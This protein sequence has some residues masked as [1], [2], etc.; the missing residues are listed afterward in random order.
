MGSIT[1]DCVNSALESRS[2]FALGASAFPSVSSS[3]RD[4][5]TLS[6]TPVKPPA[7]SYTPDHAHAPNDLLAPTGPVQ[8]SD[9][10]ELPPPPPT[11]APSQ[12]DNDGNYVEDVSVS[13][14]NPPNMETDTENEDEKLIK[15]LD[16]YLAS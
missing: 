5:H 13:K 1:R 7:S 14:I 6:A 16:N 8:E 2:S 3:S 12:D 11:E 9:T 15:K 10:A 4:V